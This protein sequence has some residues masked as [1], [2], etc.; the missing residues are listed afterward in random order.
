MDSCWIDHH[1]PLLLRY[2]RSWTHRDGNLLTAEWGCHPGEAAPGTTIRAPEANQ[3]VDARDERVTGPVVG[4]TIPLLDAQAGESPGDHKL[5]YLLGAFED[6]VA[7]TQ[8]RSERWRG[9]TSEIGRRF[10]N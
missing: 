8:M 4:A 9:E 7:A 10:T 5:L 6:V 1:C 3:H 2:L